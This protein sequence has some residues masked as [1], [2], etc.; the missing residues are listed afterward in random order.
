MKEFGIKKV[1]IQKKANE[2]FAGQETINAKGQITNQENFNNAL[3]AIMQE[4]YQGGAEK[5][6]GTTKGMFSTVTGIMKS[7]L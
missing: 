2:M 5:L 6:A 1:D 4:R 7:A 3:L